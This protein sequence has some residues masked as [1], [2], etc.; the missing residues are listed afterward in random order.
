MREEGK[1][2][3]CLAL[4]AGLVSLEPE[5]DRLACIMRGKQKEN[6]ILVAQPKRFKP[7]RLDKSARQ[8]IDLVVHNNF[9]AR[10]LPL[11]LRH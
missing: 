3:V 4:G 9:N 8:T 7:K 2:L 6:S 11:N 5:I 10:T 1:R